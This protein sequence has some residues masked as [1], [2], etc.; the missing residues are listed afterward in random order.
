LGYQGGFFVNP[1]VSQIAS[2]ADIES[3]RFLLRL[4]Q[5]VEPAGR[6]Q[7]DFYCIGEMRDEHRPSRIPLL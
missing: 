6:A 1:P 4:P 2:R 7:T 3:N 5:L